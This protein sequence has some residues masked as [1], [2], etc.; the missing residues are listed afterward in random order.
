MR[1]IALFG[2][3]LLALLQSADAS[4][5][6]CE[7]FAWSLAREQAWV[8]APDKANVAA[9]QTL[10]ALPKA[11]VV[12]HLQ[13]ASQ[14]AFDL[15]PERKPRSDQWFGGTVR[16]PAIERPGI[17]QVTLSDDAWI[18]IIQDGRYARSVGS[19]GRSD[20]PGL[21]KSVRLELGPAPFA[22]QISGV[23]SDR[24]VI[25]IGPAE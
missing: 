12:I 22:L 1:G 4:A 6:G 9:G 18:D 25:A 20:C 10:A 23:S 24:I 3:T 21:R 11:A 15:A 14:A 16:F 19:T 2:V 8:A 5:D 17:Y 7:K 13:P